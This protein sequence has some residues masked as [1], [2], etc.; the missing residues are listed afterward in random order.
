MCPISGSHPAVLTVPQPKA[1]NLS[2]FILRQ[3]EIKL[4]STAAAPVLGMK[5]T[6]ILPKRLYT[7]LY[8]G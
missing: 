3:A 4:H 5:L 6:Q 7:V 2:Q 1:S 8:S